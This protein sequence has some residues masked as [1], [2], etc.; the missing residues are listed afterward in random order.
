LDD[1]VNV[2]P[3]TIRDVAARAGV[4]HQ[5]V[6]RVINDS[7]RVT[8]ATRER[9]ANA[10]RE[11]A[12]V[13]S[14]MARGLTTNQTRSIGVVA[15][16]VSDHFFARVV[17]GAEEEARRRDYY[18]MIGSVEPD[19]EEAGYLRLM[20]E[21]RVEGLILARPSVPL[22]EA[23]L[24]AARTAGVPLVAVGSSEL[25]GIP[26]VDVDNRR[27]GYD[28]TR[29]LLEHGHRQ[30]ATIV[31]PAGWP[32]AA[33]RFDGY[34]DA[35]REAGVAEAPELVE[36]AADW[37]LESGQ[38]AAAALLGRGASFTAVF[39]HSDL[40]ALG[41][42]R[43]LRSAG[44]RVPDDVSVVGYDDLPV[45]AY[46]E[47]ALTTMHQPMGEVGALAAGIVLDQIAGGEAPEPRTHL[48]AAV[49]V[50]RESVAAPARR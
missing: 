9:V 11:L 48:L 2:R 6:S 4:S 40:T 7:P 41:A 25:P 23:D 18:L 45:A 20:L 32:S 27:G 16:D 19:E 24:A 17:A 31:G 10:I 30:I 15:D 21:R 34:R 5:T 49:L 28:A 42:I 22:E 36:H 12:Y 50:T 38:A 33:A 44:L 3:P 46:V 29:V 14:P 26:A 13:P 35:L 1:A 47:P 43:E 37:G 8:E 39:A